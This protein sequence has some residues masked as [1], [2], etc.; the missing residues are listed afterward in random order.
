MFL[1][2][3]SVVEQGEISWNDEEEFEVEQILDR[4]EEDVS[5]SHLTLNAPIAT[6]VVCFFSSA[7]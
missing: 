5:H 2:F 6:K 1:L 3:I 4:T 7:E